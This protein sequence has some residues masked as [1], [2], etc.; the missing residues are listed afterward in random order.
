MITNDQLD[1]LQKKL[2]NLVPCLHCQAEND[3]NGILQGNDNNNNNNNNNNAVKVTNFQCFQCGEH[4]CLNCNS[5]HNSE[6]ISCASFALASNHY[7][8]RA[9]CD[10]EKKNDNN[11]NNDKNV[12]CTLNPIVKDGQEWQDIV[13]DI[14]KSQAGWQANKIEKIERVHNKGLFEKY[15]QYCGTVGKALKEVRVFHGTRGTDPKLIY[16]GGFD[17]KFSRVGGCLWYA[18]NSSYSM[19]GYQYQLGNGKVCLFLCLVAGGNTNDVKYI[20]NDLILNVYKN[21][22]TYPAYLITYQQ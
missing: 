22:A 2:K 8:Y 19:G 1:R 3:P 14:K 20:R 11:N 18:I 5:L 4:N 10:D 6:R 7:F 12:V 16:N 13:K 17:K 9:W 21:E 15:I